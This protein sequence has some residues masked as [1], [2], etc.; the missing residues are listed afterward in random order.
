MVRSGASHRLA[1][2]P[3]LVIPKIFSRC[4]REKVR[5]IGFMEHL[6]L[7]I[8][9]RDNVKWNT[10]KPPSRSC[11]PMAMTKLLLAR[12]GFDLFAVPS[13]GGLAEI[14]FIGQVTGQ[15]G[16]VPENDVFNVRL[17][18]ANRFEIGPHVRLLLVPG[19]AAEG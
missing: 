7:A 17:A 10:Q 14:G 19:N 1:T 13:S 4:R 6:R 2:I 3:L 12:S 5:S 15:R 11:A 16:V 8:I 9:G 18:S